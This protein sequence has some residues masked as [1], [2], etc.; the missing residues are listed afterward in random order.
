MYRSA[1]Q[2]LKRLRQDYSLVKFANRLRRMVQ[3]P[4]H[5]IKNRV[6]AKPHN[7]KDLLNPVPGVST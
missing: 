7:A 4:H 6:P 5:P 3:Q 2:W 1:L